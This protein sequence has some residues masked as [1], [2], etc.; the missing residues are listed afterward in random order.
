MSDRAARERRTLY[1]SD[2]SRCQRLGRA[3]V[4]HDMAPQ[5]RPRPARPEAREITELRALRARHP[6]LAAAIDMQ[7]ELVELN[8]RIQLRVSTFSPVPA[9]ERLARLR[10][11]RRVLDLAD[12]P[13]EWP[14][15][16]LAARQACDILHRHDLIDSADHRVIIGL[17][18]EGGDLGPLVKAW[19]AET[20]RGPAQGTAGDRPAMLDEVLQLALRPFFGR[21]V[22]VAERGLD[23][24]AWG[25]PWCPFCGAAPDFS[26]YTQEDT[27]LLIC[28]R[29]HGRW[30]WESHGCPWCL[31]RNR[32][33]LPTFS[34]PDRRY[35][36]CACDRCHRYLKAYYAGGAPRP[37]MPT[38]DS[39]ATLPLDAAAAQRGY[40]GG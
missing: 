7:I 34:S 26:V 24:T 5:E 8:R 28:S 18:R 37:V 30:A 12:V 25:R 33:L 38:V 19:F 22:E 39:I 35:R 27:R 4:R 32:Q 6:E 20:E 13:I 40:L 2:A 1:L 23:L 29:C 15:A 11:G 36:L 16:G 3:I 17:V 10:Q 31:N 14:D 21:A 9:A